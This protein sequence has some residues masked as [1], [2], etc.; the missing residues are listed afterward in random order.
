M[1][2]C[3]CVFHFHDPSTSPAQRLTVRQEVLA[4]LVC[5]FSEAGLVMEWD[6]YVPVHLLE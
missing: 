6:Y 1:C 2:V 3:V 5:V 4:L